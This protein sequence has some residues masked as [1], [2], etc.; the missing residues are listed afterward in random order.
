MLCSSCCLV[1]IC[2]FQQFGKEQQ[3]HQHHHHSS[4]ARAPTARSTNTHLKHFLER[5]TAASGLERNVKTDTVRIHPSTHP[6]MPLLPLIKHCIHPPS[7]SHPFSLSF[8][9][10]VPFTSSQSLLSFF[11]N[12]I[13][14]AGRHSL[15]HPRRACLVNV[16][17][18]K[19]GQLRS[20]QRP[21]DFI[22]SKQSACFS[23]LAPS[24]SSNTPLL[25]HS[26]SP[27]TNNSLL[28]PA[29]N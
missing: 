25:R 5:R 24:S 6:S 16:S 19:S 27:I 2:S 23:L 7:P 12:R 3:G 4:H 14:R 13:V 21:L 20:L 10:A 15:L 29:A 11:D 17:N 28:A 18:A 1:S 26:P 9:S 8:P 22:Y